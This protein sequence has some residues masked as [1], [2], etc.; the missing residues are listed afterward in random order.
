MSGYTGNH[1]ALDPELGVFDIFLGNRCHNRV[2]R[3]VPETAAQ[4]L[5]LA[6]DGSGSVCWPDGRQVLS[7]FQYIYKKDEMLHQ[8]V[9]QCLLDSGMIGGISRGT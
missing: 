9:Y 1:F 7:S 2:S 5:G 8:P 4:A 3:I 6:D